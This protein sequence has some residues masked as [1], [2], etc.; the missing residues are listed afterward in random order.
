MLLEKDLRA[1]LTVEIL[2]NPTSFM[3][4]SNYFYDTLYHLNKI[5]R[6]KRTEDLASLIKKTPAMMKTIER[7]KN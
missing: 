4:P 3:Y 6:K 5:G 1:N 7:I 2:G